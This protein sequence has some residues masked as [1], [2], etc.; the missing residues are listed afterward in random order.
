MSYLCHFKILFDSVFM[1]FNF[2]QVLWKNLKI[3]ISGGFVLTGAYFS[4]FKDLRTVSALKVDVADMYLQ[5][6]CCSDVHKAALSLVDIA[7]VDSQKRRD[8]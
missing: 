4:V 6:F 3:G 2:S 1:H 7:S 8:Q 5:L